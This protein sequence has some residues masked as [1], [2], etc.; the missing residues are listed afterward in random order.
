[1][2]HLGGSS[3]GGVHGFAEVFVFFFDGCAIVESEKVGWIGRWGVAV[4]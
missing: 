3:G 1:M 4:S 2:G